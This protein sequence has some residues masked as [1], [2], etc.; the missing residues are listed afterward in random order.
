MYKQNTGG[1]AS[2]ALAMQAPSAGTMQK[3]QVINFGMVNEGGANNIT[4]ANASA[5][6][7][8][9][10]FERELDLKASEIKNQKK[11]QVGSNSSSNPMS[12][13]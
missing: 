8:K 12:E 4:H 9:T 2:A 1:N 13:Q 5:P 10:P 6:L 3:K 7:Q 11:M